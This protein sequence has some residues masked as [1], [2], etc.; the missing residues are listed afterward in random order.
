MSAKRKITLSE[1]QKEEFLCIQNLKSML[2][3]GTLTESEMVIQRNIMSKKKEKLVYQVHFKGRKTKE[4]YVCKDGR[5]KSQ[6]PQFIC[7]TKEQLID[8]L[9]DY[10]F[11]SSLTTVYKDWIRYLSKTETVTPKTIEENTSIWRRFL[12]NEKIATMQVAEIKPRH[13]KELFETWTGNGK[14]T[15]KDFNNRKSVLNGIFSYAFW[16]EKIAYNPVKE[17][18]NSQFK[19]K[20]P[21]AVKKAYTVEQ[22]SMLLNYLETLEPDAYVLGIMLAFH[23]IF[24]IGEIKA[25]TWDEKN[26]NQVDIY[27][28]LVEERILQDD[29]TFSSPQKRY[30]DPKGNPNYSIRTEYVSDKAVEILKKMKSLNPDKEPLFLYQGRTLTT[31]SFNRRL[32]KYCK[33][34]EIPYLSSHKI[35]FTTASMLYDS[36]VKAIDIQPLLGHSNLA[37]TQHYIGQRVREQDTTQMAKVLG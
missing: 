11:L 12:A 17:F 33:A 1:E 3:N 10:Y 30:K 27:R 13:I 32:E 2:E 4:F 29:M 28:Q 14:I 16:N 5:F 23:G 15:R 22:R 6:N 19:F 7:R 26:G 8:K 24:R 37:M 9:Y 34:I 35:R 21:N 25:L 20:M 18:S 31:E 36:G